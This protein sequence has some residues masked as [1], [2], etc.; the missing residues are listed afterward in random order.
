VFPLGQHG[1][2][3]RQGTRLNLKRERLA[4]W[5]QQAQEPGKYKG[6]AAL[7]RE[8]QK[9]LRLELGD[10]ATPQQQPQGRH[11]GEGTEQRAPTGTAAST[12]ST[13]STASAEEPTFAQGWGAPAGDML[14]RLARFPRDESRI[15][16]PLQW[17]QLSAQLPPGL[18]TQDPHILFCASRHGYRLPLLLE[19]CDH[20]CVVLAVRAAKGQTVGA[21]FPINLQQ[22]SAAA[23]RGRAG[24]MGMRGM[25]GAPFAFTV[26]S[27]GA[28]QTFTKGSRNGRAMPSRSHAEE[29]KWEQGAEGAGQASSSWSSS[30]SEAGEAMGEA[31][32]AD[33][34][35]SRGKLQLLASEEFL[36]IGSTLSL[37]L[38]LD[39]ELKHGLSSPCGLFSSPC[40]TEPALQETRNA[41]ATF[42]ITDVEVYGFHIPSY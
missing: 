19:R 34:N 6:Y 39:A 37:A 13:A 4:R 10:S 26:L 27:S 42:T 35:T 12:A 30:D 17:L 23:R 20:A 7:C 31:P 29:G 40:L 11:G 41:A 24:A 9:Q 18:Q 21:F 15:L 33:G 36:A 5:R 25:V 2:P 38:S 3:L 14:F 1:D 28:V 8:A 32:D 16:T 22:H